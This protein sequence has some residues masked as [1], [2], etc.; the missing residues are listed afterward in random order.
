MIMEHDPNFIDH[1]LSKE[2]NNAQ[3][4]EVREII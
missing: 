1:S 3:I 4:K 2:L